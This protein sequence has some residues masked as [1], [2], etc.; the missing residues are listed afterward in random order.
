L[1]LI[2]FRA[3]DAQGNMKLAE[4]ISCLTASP[5][6]YEFY[7]GTKQGKVHLFDIRHSQPLVTKEHPY[8][9][10]ILS[11]EWHSSAQKLVSVDK[12]SIRVTEKDSDELFFMFEPKHEI[13]NLKSK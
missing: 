11:I 13:N 4:G 3:A 6:P 8:E 7:L 12:K 5:N 1:D 2:D 10:P 9:F